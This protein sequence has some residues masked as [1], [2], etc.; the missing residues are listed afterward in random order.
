MVKLANPLEAVQGIGKV[1]SAGIIAEIGDIT[2]FTSQAKLAKYAG[3]TWNSNQSGE[4]EGEDEPLNRAGN[5]YLR[6]YLIEAAD[7]LRRHNT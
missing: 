1:Y 5:R 7:S 6:Y 3:L 4:F 2:K